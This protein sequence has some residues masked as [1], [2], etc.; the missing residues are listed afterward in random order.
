MKIFITNSERNFL[1]DYQFHQVTKD[2]IQDR[3]CGVLIEDTSW[4]LYASMHLPAN[5]F[6]YKR[7]D[8]HTKR[9]II[10]QRVIGDGAVPEER[11][12]APAAPAAPPV[13]DEDEEDNLVTL[14]KE[15]ASG[16]YDEEE[17]VKEI[18]DEVI[19]RVTM[20][21]GDAIEIIKKLIDDSDM[22][23]ND[24][25]EISRYALDTASEG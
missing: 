10:D 21:D 18:M 15:L 14:A 8:D 20:Y 5:A 16:E 22:D 12:P 4:Y 17:T 6:Y 19:G 13:P 3:L 2:A 1:K 9:A 7:L 25:I 11:Y 24:L 23:A